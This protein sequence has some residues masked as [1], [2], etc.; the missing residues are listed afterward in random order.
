[1]R[2]SAK[3]YRALVVL[4]ILGSTAL[5]L[6]RPWSR[7]DVQPRRLW[8]YQDSMHP[9]VKSDRPGKCTVCA[10]DLTP[11]CEGDSAF[12]VDSQ[13]VVLSSNNVTGLNVQTE[14]VRTGSL[15]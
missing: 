7:P 10:M 2:S 3:I 11:I 14:K 6:S 1:M 8:Y 4:V 13:T 12:E 5:A 9:W 15:H